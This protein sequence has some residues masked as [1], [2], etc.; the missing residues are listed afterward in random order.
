M[1][2]LAIAIQIVSLIFVG[3]GVL[4]ALW[5]EIER[6]RLRNESAPN[7]LKNAPVNRTRIYCGFGIATIGLVI[8]GIGGIYGVLT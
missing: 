4:V 6:Q 8:I 3:A 7:P 1:T 5:P 2:T